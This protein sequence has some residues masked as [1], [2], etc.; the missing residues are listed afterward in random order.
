MPIRGNNYYRLAQ[1]DMDG[2]ERI[3][4]TRS[5]SFDIARDEVS[6]YPNPVHTT[7]TVLFR[8]GNYSNAKLV[9]NNG[10]VLRIMAIARDTSILNI[11]LSGFSRGTYNL[12]LLGIEGSNAVKVIKK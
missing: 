12:L 9:D 1:V 10:K 2:T 5:V 8:A 11:D 4:E 7:A 6:V 3:L